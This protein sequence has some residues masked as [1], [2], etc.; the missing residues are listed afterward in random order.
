MIN[1]AKLKGRIAEKEKTIQIIAPEIPCS[2][3]T[4]GQQ[5]LNKV[6]MNLDTAEKLCEIL[7]ITEDE[8]AE[9]FFTQKVAITQQK[10]GNMKNLKNA[11]RHTKFKEGK[12]GRY[13]IHSS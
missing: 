2:P 5:I 9:F 10:E 1:T 8:F 7:D 6:S 11:E 13:F 4:L 3:Y 12:H